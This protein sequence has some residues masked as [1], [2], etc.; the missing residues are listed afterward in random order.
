MKKIKKFFSVFLTL[1]LIFT[2]VPQGAIQAGA[3]TTDGEWITVPGIEGGKIEFDSSTG[4]IT[5][6]NQNVTVA[7]IPGTINGVKVTSIG[8]NAFFDCTILT[9]VTIPNS[10]ISIGTQAFLDCTSL[11]G[12]T[13]G[14]SVTSIGDFA[15]L[16]CTSLTDI[17]VDVGNSAYASNGGVLFDKQFTTLVTYPGGKKGHYTIP[18]SV[19]SIGDYAF[20]HCNSLTGVTTGNSVTGI[21]EMAFAFCDS[22]TGVTIGTSVTSIAASAFLYCTSLTDIQVDVGNS[23]YASKGDVLFNKQFT[24]LVAYPGGKKGHYTIPSSVTSIGERAFD[25]CES[26]TGVTIP[27]SVTS[28]GNWAFSGCSSLTGVTIPNSVTSIARGVFEHCDSLTGVTIGDSVTSI[29]DLAFFVCKSLTSVTVP[30]SVTSIGKEAFEA[31]TSLTGV[32]IGNSVISIGDAAFRSCTSLTGVTIPNSVTRIGDAAFE[33]CT[34]LTGVTI[35]N[36]VTII[37]DWAFMECTSLTNVTIPSSVTSIR[38]CAFAYCESLTGV[39]IPNGVTSIGDDAFFRCSSLISVTIPNSVTSIARGAFLCCSSLKTVYYG[40][41]EAQWENI[42]I[43]D[44]NNELIDADIRYNSDVSGE[45]GSKCGDNLTWTYANGNLEIRGTGNMY[46]FDEAHLPPWANI[47][48]EIRSIFIWGDT[49]SIGKNAFQRCV[50]ATY[51]AIHSSVTRI[52]EGAYG[53]CEKLRNVHYGGTEANW[54][55]VQIGVNNDPLKSANVLCSGTDPWKPG[56]GDNPDRPG[57][58]ISSFNKT[59]YHSDW[60]AKEGQIMPRNCGYLRNRQTPSGILVELLKGSAMDNATGLWKDLSAV[61]DMIEDIGTVHELV[62]EEKDMYSAIILA[63]MEAGADY[64]LISSEAEDALKF[65]KEAISD[66]KAVITAD[67]GWSPGTNDAEFLKYIQK[68]PNGTQEYISQWFKKNH[69]GLTQYGDVF[70]NFSTVLKGINSIESYVKTLTSYAILSQTTESM[71]EVLRSALKISRQAYGSLHPLTMAFSETLGI[72]SKSKENLIKAVTMKEVTV[73]GEGMAR[74]LIK[75]LFWNEVKNELY[76]TMPGLAVL[77][78]G[79]KVGKTISNA[80][81]NTDDT[82]EAYL[83]MKA[84]LEVDQ[85]IA[86]VYEDM[87]ANAQSSHTIENAEKHLSAMTLVF[88]MLDTDCENAYSYVDKLDSAVLSKVEQAFGKKGYAELKKSIKSIQNSYSVDH[89]MALKG[90]VDWLEED[91]P[92][93]GLYE[94]YNGIYYGGT[95][96]ISK[97]MVIACPVNVYVKDSS[98]NIVA[99]VESDEVAC[100]AED[101]MIGKI[102]EE[103]IIHFYGTADYTIDCVGYDSGTMSVYTEDSGNGSDK[104]KTANYYDLP[105]SEETTYTASVSGS[106]SGEPCV[107]KDVANSEILTAD[108]DNSKNENAY[109]L[110]MLSG[111]FLRENEIHTE[112]SVVKGEKIDISAFVPEGYEFIRWEVTEGSCVIK[113]PTARCTSLIMPGERITVMAVMKEPGKEKISITGVSA[114]YELVYRNAPHL[115]YTGTP[116]SAY[117]GDY[118]TRYSGR[119]NTVYD[120]ADA[121]TN[122]GDYT[123]AIKIPDSSTEY[124]G[125]V[126]LDFTISKAPQ[127]APGAPELS[128]K[129]ADSVTLKTIPESDNGTVAEYSGDSGAT[130]QESPVF[131]GLSAATEY[132]FAARYA[133]TENYEDSPVSEAL[134]VI[135][136]TEATGT[137]PAVSPVPD[138]PGTELP[139]PDVPEDW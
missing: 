51:T 3:A 94:Y 119:N 36:S 105:V 97:S 21:G 38:S 133:G 47:A 95:R 106:A 77:Q 50:N 52:G 129:A 16:S 31:C 101:V 12:V 88:K 18:N 53:A 43:S 128:K 118:E 70:K 122:A 9:D 81:C 76:T 86:S 54:A 4:T 74:Y 61:F 121:P 56:P 73:I 24:T 15:F 10:V 114:A 20:R 40:G 58:N 23:A 71:E 48:G 92:N 7:N 130:W 64:D 120:S 14:T 99:Y 41:S 8:D 66:Y 55:N 45:K 69:P 72:I 109:P 87:K 46:D 136:D 33:E 134:S 91:Y 39:T 85:V 11:T 29:G 117:T 37:G 131:S 84:T 22:L 26:L 132:H 89:I 96:A 6:C 80:L 115:G 1:L 111:T 75:E 32:T 67:K 19:T 124:T 68:N 34:S 59:L 28:I 123:V 137:P 135:T 93:S 98:G 57:T 79:Y 108:F 82:I 113:D 127:A 65:F 102:G 2:V 44:G 139:S 83:K 138:D 17:Q 62:V 110:K 104:A 25:S 30:N 126:T 42:N 5:N 13:I 125:S 90:W 116:T 78:A 27:N 107:L 103:K 112:A 60:L 63:A 49:A 100:Y 35:P